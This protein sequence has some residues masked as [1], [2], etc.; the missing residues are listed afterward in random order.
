[1][2]ISIVPRLFWSPLAVLL[3]MVGTTF[4]ILGSAA[5]VPTRHVGP[6]ASTRTTFFPIPIN[7]RH[8][9]VTPVIYER[10]FLTAI[11]LKEPESESVN[12]IE[13]SKRRA[14]VY[15]KLE[16]VGHPK[17]YTH[18]LPPI[19]SPDDENPQH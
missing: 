8:P 11:A 3:A 16:F 6:I 9:V 17:Y 14:M 4:Y 5:P 10:D 15:G 19:A 2:E 13:L 18:D 12:G 7:V 1:M